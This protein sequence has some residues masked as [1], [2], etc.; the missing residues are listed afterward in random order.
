LQTFGGSGFLQDYPIEQYIRDAKIDSLYEGTTAIQA[1]DF[2]FRKIARDQGRALAHV[3]SQITD[4]LGSDA[5]RPELADGR[6]LLATALADLQGMVTSMTGYLVDAQQ[7]AREL[8]RLGLQSVPFLLAVGD[9]LIGWLLLNQAEIALN[10]LDTD[11]SDRDRSF[12]TGKVAAATFFAKNVLP[13]LTAE[14]NIVEAVD[15]TAMD[16]REEA[17]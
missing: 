8:Y 6:T 14:R 16:L 11:V 10:A 5:A 17:F 7:N 9:L 3:V 1:Q 12:Y 13:R 15:L 2:F 4:F